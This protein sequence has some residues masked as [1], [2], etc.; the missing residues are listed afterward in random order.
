MTNLSLI[1]VKDYN[2]IIQRIKTLKGIEV[3][4]EAIGDIPKEGITRFTETID[5]LCYLLSVARGT[6]I[7]WI[8]R[9]LYDEA[10][11]LIQ[12]THY[13]RVTKPFC[14][15]PIIDPT[16]AG[17]DDTKIFIEQTYLVYI[18][19]KVYWRLNR[20]TIDA[21]LDAKAEHD[22]LQMRGVKLAV[23]ME[24]LKSVFLELPECPVAEYII[25]AKDFKHLKHNLKKAI[26][27]VLKK[28]SVGEDLCGAVYGK[29]EELNRTSFK[30]ILVSLCEFVQLDVEKQDLKLF[31]ACRNS[32]V[33]NGRFCCE[34]P[35]LEER[36]KCIELSSFLDEYFFLVNFL[37]RV[38]LKLLGYSGLYMNWRLP[39][40]PRKEEV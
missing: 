7:Q 32:L 8:Y 22:H 26:S 25:P 5:D 33:H 27:E 39:G 35:K 40:P 18:E 4:C 12:R 23:A 13:S 21:Y 24:M 2:R 6:K 37:D 29:L 3:T 34:S 15:L 28:G 17:R 11:E 16:A 36:Q 1:R 38:F 9:D 19:K 31:I 20:G 30:N 10:G 14:T